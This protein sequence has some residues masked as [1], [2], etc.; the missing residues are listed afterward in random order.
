MI[1]HPPRSPLF[2]YP[3]P[4][5]SSYAITQADLNN[6]SVTNAATAH[7]D[8]TNSN[9]SDQTVTAIKNPALTLVKSATPKDH[10][11]ELQS[12]F[13]LVLRPHLGKKT[14]AHPL[15]LSSN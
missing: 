7:A 8:G 10:T 15:T 9:E 2:P 6:G 1:R 3:T 11:P 4:F 12:H 13:N 14:P 5:R